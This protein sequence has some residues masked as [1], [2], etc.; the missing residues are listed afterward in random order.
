MATIALLFA[1]LLLRLLRLD[2]QP[3]WWD[4]GY[5]V[6]F[7]TER[8]AD[9]VALTANDIHPPLYYALLHGWT[10]WVQSVHPAAL[11]IF[12]ALVGVGGVALFL[13]LAQTLYARR[14]LV[15]WPATLLL[16]VNPMHLYY[17]HEARM[18]GVALA[19]G[20]LSTVA[21]WRL[22]TARA[23]GKPNVRGAILYSV[24]AALCLYT[25]YYL[26][27]LL[28]AHLVWAVWRFRRNPHQL[29]PLALALGLA[30][31]LY[32]P[33]LLYALPKLAAYVANKVPADADEPLG[34][35][36]Y[37]VRHLLAWTGGHLAPRT[38]AG[39]LLWWLGGGVSVALI[40]TTRIQAGRTTHREQPDRNQPATMLAICVAAPALVAFALNLRL[41]F[42]PAGGERLL[43]FVLP[44][45]LLLLADAVER[46]RRGLGRIALLALLLAAAGGGWRFYTL[47]RYAEHDYRPLIRQIVQQSATTDT[48]LAIFPWEVGYWRAYAMTTACQSAPAACTW[49]RGPE[50][51]GP[52]MALLDNRSIQWGPA[53][54]ARIDEALG[55][56]ALWFAAPLGFGSTLPDEIERYLAQTAVN[57]ADQWMTPTTRLTAWDALPIPTAQLLAIDFGAVQLVAAGVGPEETV[58]A[59]QPLAVALTWAGD[60]INEPAAGDLGATVRLVD[61][62]GYTW[63]ARTY[64]PLGR[65]SGPAPTQP[66]RDVVGLRA[67]VGIPPGDYALV[68][69]VMVS[70]AQTLLQPE[71]SARGAKQVVPVGRV[72]VRAPETALPPYRLPIQ[73]PLTPP[74]RV[75]GVALLGSAGNWSDGDALLAG[76]A[77][78]VTLFWQNEQTPPPER[79]LLVRLFDA[80]GGAVAGWEGMSLPGWSGGAWPPTGLAQA[81]LR[82][83]T[84]ATLPTGRYTL[85][86]DWS[87]SADGAERMTDLG[88]VYIHQRLADFA[89]PMLAEPLPI[90]VQFGAHV[91][92]L[93]AAQARQ[94][95]A[96]TLVLTWQVMQTLLPPHHIFVHVVADGE[97]IA[98]VDGPPQT[99]AG[100]APSGSWRAGEY[101]VTEHHLTLPPDLRNGQVRVGL[102]LPEDGVR[103]PAAIDGSP[104]GDAAV[105]SLAP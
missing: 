3:L 83:F 28:L 50:A 44:Y 6:Y 86:A 47:P 72:R 13:R 102:Y 2:W 32:L 15:I 97:V 33:W 40:L 30:F 75:D 12:S 55:R 81:P 7:A 4:E 95:D 71:G 21:L 29:R 66:G 65:L 87:G 26:A 76:E 25:L 68:A 37:I 93:S 27:L 56:G 10:Q 31:L 41:P 23:T 57:L 89:V 94:G 77:V 22:T 79:L 19:L 35:L 45:F 51:E 49:L 36:G 14:P 64:S 78:Q 88:N 18:Y 96:L 67:P 34:P 43:L 70:G 92:L 52:H 54:M 58:A 38:M 61:S 73:R 60:V 105:L 82:F 63:A 9:M 8:L 85:R 46:N 42:F 101:L 98:Q 100:P 80:Q 90:P 48:V 1:A 62:A 84:P 16:V 69:G 11:R 74:A 53:V 99:A 20:L 103:L 59:N 5:S 39:Q 24:S 17:S 91:R 104:A